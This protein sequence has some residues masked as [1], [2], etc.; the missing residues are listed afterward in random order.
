MRTSGAL[1]SATM[2]FPYLSQSLSPSPCYQT[3][4]SQAC[5]CLGEN[6]SALNIKYAV[7]RLKSLHA[8]DDGESRA[9]REEV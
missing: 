7:K 8:D 2:A 1:P 9:V 3:F 4:S 5:K 6:Q